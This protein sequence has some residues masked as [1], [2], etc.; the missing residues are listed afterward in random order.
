MIIAIDLRA[1]TSNAIS[2]VEVYTINLLNNLLK[3]DKKNTYVLYVNAFKNSEKIFSHFKNKNYKKVQTRIPN[4]IFNLSLAIFRYPKLDKIIIKRTGLTPDIF[5]IPDLRPAP[6]TKRTKKIITIHDLSFI[7]FPRF[8]SLKTRLWYRYIRPKKEIHEA[9]KLISV[10]K[11]TA[12][13]VI[14]TFKI[15]PDKITVVYEGANEDLC[16][17]ISKQFAEQVSKKF[18]LP[19]KYFL[20]F[21]TLEPRKNLTNLVKAFQ[22]FKHTEFIHK[23]VVCGTMNQKVFKKM[24]LP[25]DRDIIYTGFVTEKEKPVLYKK[26]AALIYPSYF[27]GFGLPIV[28]AMKC[29]TP[30]ITSNTSSMPEIAGDSALLINPNNYMEIAK[31]MQ[32]IIKP[33]QR[34]RLTKAMTERNKIFDWENSAKKTLKLFESTY[35]SADNPLETKQRLSPPVWRK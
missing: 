29:G 12:A 33:Q 23:L 32:K 5:F 11:Y 1:L 22:H 6:V 24:E 10:S 19:E 20:F 18:N 13:D 17:Q 15:K 26:A 30:V 35:P 27:E 14:K 3:D 16:S 9:T 21:A 7:H 31:A 2:G 25:R 34:T 4:K 8:F 28:E